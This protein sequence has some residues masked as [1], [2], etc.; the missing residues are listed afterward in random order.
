MIYEY[1]LSIVR[2]FNPVRS[3]GSKK[4]IFYKTD[5]EIEAIRYSCELVGKTHAVVAERIRPG[6]RTSLL[7]KLAE[8][9][10][11][12]HKAVPSFKGYNGFPHTL[13]MSIN[14][15]VVHGMPSN[16]EL[17]SGD[18]VSIDCGVFANG[19]HG[20]S[21]YTYC[22]GE[23]DEATK[24][25]LEVTK[26]SLYKGI[27]QAVVGKRLGDICFAIQQHAERKHGYGVVRELVGHGVGRQLH[28]GPEVPNY[29]KRGKGIKLLNGLVLA[30]EPMINLGKKEVQCLEDGWTV[31]TKD[32]SP[33]AHFEHTVAVRQKQAEILSTFEYLEKAIKNNIELT[34]IS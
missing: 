31:V 13:C 28:E 32:D 34:E 33:S 3:K 16:Y 9:F 20:D 1:I 2:N 12:D 5:D 22:V 6:I 15:E 18:I 14:S 29:G 7:D 17:K 25:L 26:E 27:E 23:I 4:N 21:A 30:I 8:E 19:F 10:I 11:K 24:K